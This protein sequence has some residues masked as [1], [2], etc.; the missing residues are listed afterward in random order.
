[1]TMPLD[2]TKAQE[3]KNI[4]AAYFAI[5]MDVRLQK[6][7]ML[8]P[9]RPSVLILPKPGTD[10]HR[11]L[12]VVI[13]FLNDVDDCNSADDWTN[14]VTELHKSEKNEKKLDDSSLKHIPF[15]NIIAPAFSYKQSILALTLRAIRSYVLNEIDS[16]LKLDLSKLEEFKLDLLDNAHV[17]FFEVNE[18]KQ[19]NDKF[20][21]NFEE[22]LLKVSSDKSILSIPAS[23]KTLSKRSADL[24]SIEILSV[25]K[26]P[27]VDE[28]A[29]ADDTHVSSSPVSSASSSG[30][31]KPS[32]IATYASVVSST[33]D[34]QPEETP[35]P[36]ATTLRSTRARKA[37]EAVLVQEEKKSKTSP[38]ESNVVAISPELNQ[39]S[40][41]AMP[42]AR[43]RGRKPNVSTPDSEGFITVGSA[44]AKF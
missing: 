1:M 33:P 9:S 40:V 42:P 6:W 32:P 7:G 14:F 13:R 26:E 3:M 37:K 20:G 21:K 18:T 10:Q 15:I 8:N 24:N 36:A 44:R 2:K 29:L 11:K 27:T 23:L 38:A 28:K 30:F 4:V 19:R 22:F 41:V 34:V 16:D 43:R 17:K 12:Q 31:F 5:F 25:D 39:S 35:A